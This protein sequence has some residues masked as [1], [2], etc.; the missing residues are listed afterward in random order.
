MGHIAQN[1]KKLLSRVRRIGGQ[2]SALEAAVAKQP[3]CADV[4][5][6]IAAIRGAVH[7]LLI[8]VMQEHLQAHVASPESPKQRATG[9]EEL[10]ALM[11]TYLK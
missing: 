2:V 10:A 4:L 1:P 7:G 6:Q 3:D 8:E 5:V 9:A 11:R